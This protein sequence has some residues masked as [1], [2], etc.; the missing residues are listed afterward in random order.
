MLWVHIW[1]TEQYK[2]SSDT[3]TGCKRQQHPG[4]LLSHPLYPRPPQRSLHLFRSC[5]CWWWGGV[6]RCRCSSDLSKPLWRDVVNCEGIQ[7]TPAPLKAASESLT[8]ASLAWDEQGSEAVTA[9]EGPAVHLLFAPVFILCEI[10]CPAKY[11][12][13]IL[14]FLVVWKRSWTAKFCRCSGK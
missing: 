6:W 8:P 2:L 13:H 1:L 14:N 5:I 3:R 11:T 7:D 9:P 12:S 4:A 10:N